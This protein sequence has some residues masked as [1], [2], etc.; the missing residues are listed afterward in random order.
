MALKVMDLNSIDGRD[1]WS[2]PAI[3]ITE[4]GFSAL[5]LRAK[6]DDGPISDCDGTTGSQDIILGC[7]G[8]CTQHILLKSL[9][10]G[11]RAAAQH[12]GVHGLAKA[13]YI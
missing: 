4:Q 7:C 10:V 11:D 5:I 12:E 8:S 1:I 13:T 3:V 9:K 2:P 6:S